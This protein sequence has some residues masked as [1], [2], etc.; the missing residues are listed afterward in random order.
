[1]STMANEMQVEVYWPEGGSS[2]W[3]TG[4]P[5]L[6]VD[7]VTPLSASE[8]G[9]VTGLLCGAGVFAPLD[10]DRRH[11]M[12]MVSAEQLAVNLLDVLPGMDRLARGDDGGAV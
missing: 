9:A 2:L 1:M 12:S 5:I 4:H 10:D 7:G 11:F 8:L 6:D 3:R